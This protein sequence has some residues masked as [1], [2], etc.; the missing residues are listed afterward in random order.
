V[1]DGAVTWLRNP[2][3]GDRVRAQLALDASRSNAEIARA[4]GCSP[5]TVPRYRGSFAPP[6]PSQH[7]R[8]A[9]LDRFYAST[10]V[11]P[12]LSA[13]RCVTHPGGADLW[14]SRDREDQQAALFLCQA[15][16]CLAECRSWALS[17]PP[18][19]GVI[20]GGLTP[21]QLAQ[22]RTQALR[23]QAEQQARAQATRARRAKSERLR[24]ALGKGNTPEAARQRY[25]ADPEPAK[26]RARAYYQA[27]KTEI[28]VSRHAARRAVG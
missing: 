9:A 14:A 23:E 26:A 18:S 19:P 4:A 6:D 24:Y 25:L 12:D 21:Y 1:H 8:V 27:N 7:A 13:G 11:Q 16:P 5:G 3:A 17:L 22:A 28:L 10:P 2:G 20:I 15:C